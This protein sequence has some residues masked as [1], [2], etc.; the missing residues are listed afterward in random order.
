MFR[1]REAKRL[2]DF[3]RHLF[4]ARKEVLLGVKSVIDSRIRS[5]EKKV[6]ELEKAKKR[7]E[8]IP[9]ESA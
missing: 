2:V 6:S 9:V 5:I 1:K 7:G 3:R 4:N 8:K